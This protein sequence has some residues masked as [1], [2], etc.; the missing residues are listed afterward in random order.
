VIKSF[1]ISITHLF[2][3]VFKINSLVITYYVLILLEKMTLHEE[4][5]SQFRSKID[6]QNIL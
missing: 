3:N 6:R 4:M 2:G 1:E 5:K